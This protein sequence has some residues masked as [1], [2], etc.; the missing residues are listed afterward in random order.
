MD[1]YH[2]FL[3]GDPPKLALCPGFYSQ[4]EPYQQMGF[5]AQ[6]RGLLIALFI[7]QHSLV[8]SC[9]SQLRPDRGFL[10]TQISPL[11]PQNR[12]ETYCYRISIRRLSKSI[13]F[14]R[15]LKENR[16]FFD[17]RPH[18]ISITRSQSHGW[19]RIQ[20]PATSHLRNHSRRTQSQTA[21]S[22]STT[23]LLLL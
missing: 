23:F 13:L 12:P 14:K 5:A 15:N 19:A 21:H 8:P 3:R 17:P 7:T 10:I 6:D 20:A 16:W 4:K 2:S 18:Q 9:L 11:G 1:F 22:N